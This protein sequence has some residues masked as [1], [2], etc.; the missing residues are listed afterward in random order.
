MVQQLVFEAPRRGKPPRHLADL[1]AA[2]YYPP[3][4]RDGMIRNMRD[5]FH[6]MEMTEQDVRTWHGAVRALAQGRTRRKV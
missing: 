6:R 2:G 3:A 5:M 4:K 1:D